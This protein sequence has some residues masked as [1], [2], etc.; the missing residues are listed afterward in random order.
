M[1]KSFSQDN[2]D[3]EE[4]EEAK[5]ASQEV[6]KTGTDETAERV[7]FMLINLFPLK[8]KRFP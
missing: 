7:C 1:S 8:F 3:D 4:E 5:T 2:W 6:K